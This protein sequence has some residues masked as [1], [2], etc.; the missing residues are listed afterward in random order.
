M[1]KTI[2]PC[3][4][5]HDDFVPSLPLGTDKVAEQIPLSKSLSVHTGFDGA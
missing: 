5:L 3:P 4:H 1:A 2:E